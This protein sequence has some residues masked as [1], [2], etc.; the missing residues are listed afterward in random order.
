MMVFIFY[1]IRKEH[2]KVYIKNLENMFKNSCSSILLK[3]VILILLARSKFKYL[4]FQ[5]AY[6]ALQIVHVLKTIHAH[7]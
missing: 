4:R 7:L 6:F 1:R 3:Q 5:S 2:Y